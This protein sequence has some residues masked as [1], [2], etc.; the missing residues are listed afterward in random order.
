MKECRRSVVSIG[1]RKNTRQGKGRSVR[2][3][4]GIK[5]RRSENLAFLHFKG[6]FFSAKGEDHLWK[7]TKSGGV[8]KDGKANALDVV[9]LAVP[10]QNAVFKGAQQTLIIVGKNGDAV[11]N[12]RKNIRR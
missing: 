7:T 2:E 11:T 9:H 5:A 12:I 4:E 3:L 6:G 8:R 1:V 10:A